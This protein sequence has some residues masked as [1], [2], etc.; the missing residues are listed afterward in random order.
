MHGV[1]LSTAGAVQCDGLVGDH[2]ASTIGGRRIDSVSIE[3]G[4]GA[5]HEE[6]ACLMQPVQAAKV[7]I[8]SIHDVDGA[9]LGYQHIERM[10]VVQLA[11][12]DMD[13]AR[14]VAAQIE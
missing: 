7:D 4:L 8:P 2:T 3:I 1:I 13:K 6:G 12:R 14:N 10:N 5:G 9:S 11:I